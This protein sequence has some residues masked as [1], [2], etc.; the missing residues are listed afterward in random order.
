MREPSVIVWGADTPTAGREK[1]RPR[2]ESRVQRDV[3]YCATEKKI[4]GQKSLETIGQTKPNR[5]LYQRDSEALQW[6]EVR[7]ERG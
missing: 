2:V 6:A 3:N 5:F 1:P 7:C 4:H